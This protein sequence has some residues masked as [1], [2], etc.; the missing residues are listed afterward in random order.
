MARRKIIELRVDFIGDHNDIGVP[1]GRGKILHV[2]PRHYAA[3]GIVGIRENDGLRAGR[4]VFFHH[5]AGEFKAI[6]RACRNGHAFAAGK[7]DAGHVGNVAG[8]RHEHL[9]ARLDQS[10]HGKV[11]AL[12]CADRDHN[13]RIGA[14]S[15]AETGFVF[16]NQPCK[17]LK[18]AVGGIVRMA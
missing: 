11:D 17:L 1:D 6:L 16:G 7:G 13:L 4:D 12:A 5:F 2:L 10:A 18:A 15:D 14:I 9:I 3:R 8:V